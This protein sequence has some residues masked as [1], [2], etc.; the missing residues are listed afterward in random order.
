MLN[1]EQN[2]NLQNTN[3]FINDNI[4]KLKTITSTTINFLDE[5][6]QDIIINDNNTYSQKTKEKF[7]NTLLRRDNNIISS[8]KQLS[9]VLIGITFLEKKLSEN[10]DSNLDQSDELD[11]C[12]WKI[13][14]RHSD[15]Q[16]KNYEKNTSNKS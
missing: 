6:V 5:S 7:L 3:T 2:Q 14:R 15:E 16:L 11:E 10:K 1:T 13:L 4:A 12:D 8:I 9:N